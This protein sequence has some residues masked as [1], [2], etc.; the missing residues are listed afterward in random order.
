MKALGC[1]R[2]AF[3]RDVN[4]IQEPRFSRCYLPVVD[5]FVDV[6][7][8]LDDGEE[9]VLVDSFYRAFEDQHRGSRE[10]IK[11]RL[12]K[13]RPFIAP[14]ATLYPGGKAFDL[15]CGRGEWLELM[16]ESGFAAIGV[17]LDGDMLEACRERGLSV[18][19]GDA[20]EYLA[21]LDANSHALVSAFHVVEH[22][23]FEQVRRIVSEALRVLK[24]GGL[25][26]LETPNP[27]NIVVAGCNFYLDPSHVRPI[28]S[29]LLSFV[30]EYAGF[31]RVKRIRLQES[32][33]LQEE[34]ARAHLMDVLGGVSPDYAIV[35]QKSC[36]EADA[37]FFD[38][39][40]DADYGLSLAE[41][42]ARFEAGAAR[43]HEHAAEQIEQTRREIGRLHQQTQGEIERLHGELG[44]TR[45]EVGGTRRE[46]MRAVDE[47]A[48]IRSDLGRVRGDLAQVTGE[49][50]RV[51]DDA[52]HAAE[53]LQAVYG[54][55]SWRVTAPMRSAVTFARG[56]KATCKSGV[57]RV[58]FRSVAYVNR[59]PR[60]R[61]L[62][63]RALGAM[64]G[65]KQRLV[66]IIVGAPAQSMQRKPIDDDGLTPRARE[67]YMALK[68]AFAPDHGDTE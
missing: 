17:D 34:G 52:Q 37:A 28:P 61:R 8:L 7:W 67:A 33:A 22:V 27:E 16:G 54:S 36:G 5:N 56:A 65:V 21:A 59:N 32:P 11:S 51:Q 50:R 43:A 25:L 66:R 29:E 2:N 23:S 13:Y 26:I 68:S 19:Q 24:P 48:Q 9:F 42:A 39:A 45:E 40:F 64:P 6:A 53:R 18:F 10:L 31:A 57:R 47:L 20:I 44:L 15:G 3:T 35:A 30:G 1:A 58:L 62:A 14:L 63:V 60:L 4:L 12:A 55:T 38:A 49:L 46:L 41:L